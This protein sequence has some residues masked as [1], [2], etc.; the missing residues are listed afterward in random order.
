MRDFIVVSYYTFNTE[1][2]RA[3]LRLIDSLKKFKIPYQVKGIDN[4]GAWDRNTHYKALFIKEMIET[5]P[6]DKNIVFL[7]ADAVVHRYP[8]LFHEIEEDFA[9]H[10]YQGKQLASGTLYFKNSRLTKGLVTEWIKRN[11]ENPSE[12]DQANLQER[13]YTAKGI[14]VLR[15]KDLPP[16]YCKIFDLMAD[17]KD[18]V[19][20][21]FQLSRRARTEVSIYAQEKQKYAD[22]WSAD[23]QSSRCA[24]PLV[25]YVKQNADPNWKMLD[26]GCGDGSTVRSLR[27]RN[28]NAY[29]CDITLMGIKDRC[30]CSEPYFTEAPIWNMP[31]S[32]RAFDF[33]F[34][35]DVLEHIPP[36]MVKRSI[37][38]IFR[39]TKHKTFHCIANTF[40]DIRNGQELHLSRHPMEQWGEWFKEEN[41]NGISFELIDRK[42]FLK[43]PEY[44]I[45]G[46]ELI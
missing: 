12:L 39:V 41:N 25:K 3:S 1:Y 38:E 21:H 22:L 23:Y 8:Q 33:T 18:P 5:A 45:K 13:V 19:I 7:D 46:G 44:Q 36:A 15:V 10:Y 29:G 35:T 24:L 17:I 14:G 37:K 30:S 31:F 43:I 26:I 2:E 9:A 32:D 27:S 34:S 28:L 4:I 40:S 6:A 42:E 16:E 11:D 20:E